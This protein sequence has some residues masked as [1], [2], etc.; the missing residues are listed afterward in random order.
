MNVDLG[1]E[2]RR[3]LGER[4]SIHRPG[5]WTGSEPCVKAPR[6]W[7]GGRGVRGT[8]GMG[9]HSKLTPA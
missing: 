9:P 3:A 1:E 2:K 4:N 8:P 5:G 6:E 7:G